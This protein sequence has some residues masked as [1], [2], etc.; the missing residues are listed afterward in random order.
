MTWF[1]LLVSKYSVG[2]CLDFPWGSISRAAHWNWRRT[3]AGVINAADSDCQ[4]F[5]YT[6]THTSIG[7]LSVGLHFF[8]VFHCERFSFKIQGAPRINFL[9]T[10]TCEISSLYYIYLVKKCNRAS[11]M[12][13]ERKQNQIVST[14]RQS[15]IHW[16]TTVF[17]TLIT[18][19]GILLILI[20]NNL[21]DSL[22]AFMGRYAY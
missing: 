21:F 18:E 12:T 2:E 11:C 19:K 13:G 5:L 15:R 10:N 16:T 3:H 17:I 20:I 22:L 6:H 9:G 14:N 4:P 1:L 7:K 8:L